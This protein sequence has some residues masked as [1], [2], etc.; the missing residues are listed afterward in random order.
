MARRVV[1]AVVGVLALVG[2]QACAGNPAHDES[3][4]LNQVQV[5]GS[6]NS[7][8][9][10]A[11]PAESDL[12]RQFIGEANNELMYRHAPLPTQFSE[13]AIRQIE[14]DIFADR[15]GGRYANPLIRAATGGGPYDPV[16]NEPGIKVLH[17]QDVDYRSNCLTFVACLQQ[18]GSWS[19]ANPTH[20][21]IA[22][23]VE[24]KDDPLVLGDFDFVVPEPFDAAAMD[25]IDAEIRSVF[26]EDQMI[27][28][29]DVRGDHA[30]LEQA[31]RTDGWPTL[32]ASRGKVLFLMDNEEPKRSVYVD[33]NPSLEG[34]VMF[35]NSRPG[36]PDAAFVK[37]NDPVGSRAEITQL[38]KDGYIVRTMAGSTVEARANDT[39]RRDAAFA[40]GAQWVSTDFPVPDYGIG[41][42]T[43][44]VVAI[45][46]GTV[47]RCN[48]VNAPPACVDGLIDTI[49][50]AP[51][52][53][54]TTSAPTTTA[55][56]P[57]STTVASSGP[58]VAPAAE[59][60]PAAADFSG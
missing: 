51:S 57:S 13:Q 16:M 30:T 46:G 24:L 7:Y 44:L 11:L 59:P 31:V 12:R 55:L 3:V 25:G 37:R 58:V 49:R 41:F 33:G 52:V 54:T 15:A 20:M 22:I 56:P 35:T 17:V 26:S 34:R 6:H 10:E 60:V 43:D 8:H 28:P 21:P 18:V 1:M 50:R 53:P 42:E 36:R 19:A 29:D 2:V 39:T 9:L 48:P 4:R 23:L 32:A 14:L 5:V 38:V 40:G 47:A 27:T 45:P